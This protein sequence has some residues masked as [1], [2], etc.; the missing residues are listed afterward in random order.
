MHNHTAVL[1]FWECGHSTDDFS[2]LHQT[3][4]PPYPSVS[5]EATEQ[6][7]RPRLDDCKI[8]KMDSMELLF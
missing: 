5:Y 8:W 4:L 6:G 3:S 2:P 7:S 1:E